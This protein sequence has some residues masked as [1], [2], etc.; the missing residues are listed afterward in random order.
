MITHKMCTCAYCA[1]PN[2]RPSD[3][4]R[5]ASA[6]PVHRRINTHPD[7]HYTYHQD[8]EFLIFAHCLPLTEETKLTYLRIEI[9]TPPLRSP[10][11]RQIL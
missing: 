3:W 1:L 8:H 7:N 6:F 2:V 4:A 5:I 9:G 11:V 10:P